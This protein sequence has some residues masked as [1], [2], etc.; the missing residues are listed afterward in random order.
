M[1]TLYGRPVFPWRFSKSVDTVKLQMHFN[2]EN[3]NNAYRLKFCMLGVLVGAFTLT[4]GGNNYFNL[5]GKLL[6][7]PNVAVLVF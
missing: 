1:A 5:L 3:A 2:T 6:I 4:F 7:S